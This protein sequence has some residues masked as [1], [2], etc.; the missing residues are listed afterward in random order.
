MNP[1]GTASAGRRTAGWVAAV[2]VVVTLLAA[3]QGALG[4]L[5]DRIRG[6]DPV[7]YWV[8]LPSVLLDGDLELT[9]DLQAVFGPDFEPARTPAGRVR[10]LFSVGPALLWSPFF[11]LG[12]LLTLAANL[13]G[14][15][16]ASD[17]T[18][19]LYSVLLML[20]QAAYGLAGAVLLARFLSARWGGFAAVAAVAA[21]LTASPLTF[22]LWGFAPMSHTVSFFAVALV[23]ETWR[24]RGSGFRCGLAVGLA[25]CVRW[26]DLAVA[27]VPLA[28]LAAGSE[29]AAAR[30]GR[31]VRLGA[32]VVIGAAPQLACWLVLYGAAL[33]VPQGSGFLELTRPAVVDVL[34]STRHGLLSWHPVLVVGLVGLA[35]LFRRDRP[36]ALGAAIA[37]GLTLWVSAAT[38]DWWA[39]WSFGNRRFVGML[40][41]LAVG[42]AEVIGRARTLRLRVAVVA[43]LVALAIWN[44]LFLVQYREG[45]VPR[46][47]A[48]TLAEMTTDKLRLGRLTRARQGLLEGY[49]AW[50]RGDL[51]SALASARRARAECPAPWGADA[52]QGVS[53]LA[54]GRLGEAEDGLAAWSG[55]VPDEW[56]PR[57]ALAEVH[58]ARGEWD[59]AAEMVS[60]LDHPAASRVAAAI[61]ARRR[62]LLDESFWRAADGWLASRIL[63]VDDR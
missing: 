58:A 31:L 19:P 27:A 2:W 63:L 35:L 38:E 49:W 24:T 21:V 46:A 10:N 8:Y 6:E 7:Y 29:A 13:A 44:Q 50:R 12:H 56:L 25:F 40:P 30:M 14:A 39:G 1:V 9:D 53:A 18:G 33:T 45:L 41:L 15:G 11:L 54:A 37:F 26:Q 60:S 48:L 43:A 57:W 23:L 5:G 4:G 59:R 36:L 3:G 42:L 32:G 62:P 22:E 52:L 28:A 16:L 51:E 20:G 17:G 61:A 34:L 55:R 47:G